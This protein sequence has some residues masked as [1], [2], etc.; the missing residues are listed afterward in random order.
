MTH[1][2]GYLFSEEVETYKKDP[3]AITSLIQEFF[4]T[5]GIRTHKKDTGKT[6]EY[7]AALKKWKAEGK[8]GEKPTYPRAVVEV[9]FHSMRHSFVSLCAA[10]GV[11]QVAIQHLVG[12]GSPEMTRLY[13]H[14]DAQQARRAIQTLPT[15]E[16]LSG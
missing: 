10:G 15:I 3:S 16:A 4:E 5:C 7:K 14:S 8:K 1:G 11:P 13:M 2:T 6:P 12:H 9:G